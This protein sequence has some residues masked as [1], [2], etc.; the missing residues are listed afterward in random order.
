MENCP[1]CGKPIPEGLQYCPSCIE[2][3]V[4]LSAEIMAHINLL[5]KKIEK[6]PLNAKLHLDLAEIYQKHSYN[7]QALS[8][9]EKAVHADVKNFD[10]HIKSAH[11]YLK[12]RETKKAENAFRAALHVNPKSTESLIG[13][14]RT[15]Y[16]QDRTEEA[17]VLCEKI[18]RSKPDNVEFH[19]LLKNLYNK[20]GNKE[21]FLIELLKLESLSPD[22]EQFVRE[23]A[24]H[25]QNENNMEKA[26]EYYHKMLNLNIEDIDLGFQIGK[27]HYDNREYDK[28]I[29]HLNGLLKLKNITLE[30]DAMTRTYMALAC[31]DKGDIPEAKKIIGK[32]QPS[33]AQN[34]DQEAQKKLASL[35]FKIGQ[36]ELHNNKAKKAIAFFEKALSFDKETIDY[37]RVLDKTKN[38]S[39]IS[40]KKVLK[41]VSVIAVGAVAV[42]IFIVFVW[43]L[44]HN[45]IIID[46]EPAENTTLLIDGK[47]MKTKVENPGIISSPTLL[48]GKHD[49]E[50][51]KT[52]YEK[53]Q[54]SA[55][56]GFGKPARLK[57]TLVPIHFFLQ[58]TSV[59]ESTAVIIDGQFVGKT[60]F[61]S[62]RM[63]ACPHVIEMEC[64]GHAKWRTILTVNERDSIDLGIVRLK[65]LAGKWR[66]KI[67]ENSYAYNAGFNMT[68]QQTATYLIVKF[69]HKPREDCFYTGKIK[70]QIRNGEFHAEGNITYKYE[71]VFYW[72]QTKKKI[73]MQGKISDNWDR[74][75][76]KYKV[77]SLAE[78]N[79]WANR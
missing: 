38:E 52:G 60:P 8:E 18:V 51:E 43:I 11:I 55:N 49:I 24:L 70:G 53:W 72:A 40:N 62:D 23:I 56:I 37:A 79:W 58:L 16:L 39:V 4:D 71:K 41:K 32:I 22:S 13:L 1:E 67:G 48:M 31:L 36:N 78:Q 61:S 75:E 26:K 35:F 68:I 5:K 3:P 21:K 64:A 7:K 2:K 59:P 30:R 20:K 66:G 12:F 19:I 73:A 34:M 77:E 33:Y 54:G 29:E 15:Y 14:F 27:Y 25:Y 10:A 28:A 76:G 17:I 50:I 57:V 63:L 65:N 45:K 42:S 46:I 6:E 44:T 47:S 69:Y 9:Y 74:I